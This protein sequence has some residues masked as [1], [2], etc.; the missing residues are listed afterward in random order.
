[1]LDL[2]TGI[3]CEMSPGINFVNLSMSRLRGYGSGLRHRYMSMA[4]VQENGESGN[5]NC[6]WLTTIG[7]ATITI[8]LIML[9]QSSHFI[10]NY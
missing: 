1:M 4:Q 3:G 7:Y 9:K 6:V 8:H 10:I 2:V 5:I